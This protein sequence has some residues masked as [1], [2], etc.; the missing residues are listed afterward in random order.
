MRKPLEGYRVFDLT[1]ATAGP[2]CAAQL[3]DFGAEVIHIESPQTDVTRRLW[4]EFDGTST[5]YYSY[6]RNKKSMILDL[7]DPD[8]LEIAKK[9]LK[10]CDILVENNRPGVMER[11]GLSYQAVKK[12]NPSIVYASISGFGQTGPYRE[13]AAYDG[14]IQAMSGFMTLTGPEGGEPTKA[15][16]SM[17]DLVSGLYAAFG[18]S[19]AML[20]RERTGE[21][22]YVD[23]SMLDTFTAM[24]ENA[25][26]AYLN[27][28]DDRRAMGNLHP[29][30]AIFGTVRVKDGQIMLCMQK[31]EQH[32]KLFRLL[33]LPDLTQQARFSSPIS[34]RRN[35]KE[36]LQI[37]E[38]KTMRYTRK[39]LVALL[40]DAGLP[41]GEIYTIP[42]MLQD[43][44]VQYRAHVI[45]IQDSKN[46]E[47]YIY[48]QPLVFSNFETPQRATA[49]QA[50][51]HNVQILTQL[52]G[53]SQ[54][55]AE[56]L[57]KQMRKERN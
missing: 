31:Q 53:Y 12:I 2:F 4:P 49:A 16:P 44:Q 13:R 25:I 3:A 26:A 36:L 37:V 18:I 45:P 20:Q 51:E 32:Q 47:A 28:G 56:A 17:A 38:E 21:G 8:G 9:L 15:G 19:I 52:L 57:D 41:A 5:T 29:Q 10:T 34:R 7:K 46:K 40:V 39:E 14:I 24:N 1:T 30:S 42:E 22:G 55:Q 23:C 27:A 54:A 48:G 50:G 43:E 11:L 35:I 6:N 33:E